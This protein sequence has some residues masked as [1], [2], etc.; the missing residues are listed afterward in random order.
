MKMKLKEWGFTLV[1]LLVIITMIGILT[2]IGI[3]TYDG[4]KQDAEEG[5]EIAEAY[6]ACIEALAQCT[7]LGEGGCTPCGGGGGGGE[8][9]PGGVSIATIGDDVWFTQSYNVGTQVAT[10]TL[11]PGEKWCWNNDSANCDTGGGLYSW[12]RANEICSD[13]WRLPTF[14]EFND[15]LTS[16]GGHT[17]PVRDAILA[18]SNDFLG[19]ATGKREWWGTWTLSDRMYFWADTGLLQIRSSGSGMGFIGSTTSEGGAVRCVQDL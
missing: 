9:T 18:G 5:K 15:L 13:G 8:S 7:L 16:L 10:N 6:Q 19:A 3:A 12:E 2:A 14:A 11:Q 4:Y 17:T 1:E